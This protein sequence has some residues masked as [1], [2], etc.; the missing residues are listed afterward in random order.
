MKKKIIILIICGLIIF[1]F[2][3]NCIYHNTSLYNYDIIEY[4]YLPKIIQDSLSRRFI[5]HSSVPI[6]VNGEIGHMSYVSFSPI[7]I[8]CNF[9]LRHNTI[10]PWISSISLINNESGIEYKLKYNTPPP[11]V[12]YKGTYL[13]IPEDYIYSFIEDTIVYRKYSLK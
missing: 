9:S 1:F 4:R 10:G 12:V 3:K 5:E 2:C 7:C 11:F 13:Y 6:Q 8:D